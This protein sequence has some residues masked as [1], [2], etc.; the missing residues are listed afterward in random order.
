[1]EITAIFSL[2]RQCFVLGARKGAAL[3]THHSNL[4]M[5]FLC[6]PPQDKQV[7]RKMIS[8]IQLD[9]TFKNTCTLK[10]K[11]TTSPFLL[12]SSSPLNPVS[13]PIPPTPNLNQPP[14]LRRPSRHSRR[15]RRRLVNRIIPAN[16][17]ALLGNRRRA[18]HLLE[19]NRRIIRALEPVEPP[20]APGLELLREAVAGTA[21]SNPSIP[22]APAVGR[23]AE[24]VRA[25]CRPCQPN[26]KTTTRNNTYR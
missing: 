18:R 17:L 5:P 15:P 24:L 3:A 16:A 1:M 20:V 23:R 2:R 7:C 10:R 9:A 26:P 11:S 12:L 14:P 13:T 4:D 19:A 25:C 6:S 21:R 22:L 8:Y